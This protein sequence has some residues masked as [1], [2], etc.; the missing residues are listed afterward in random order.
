MDFT[1]SCRGRRVRSWW[2]PEPKGNR[3]RKGEGV[4]A[5]ASVK[6]RRSDA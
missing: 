4:R 3:A 5:A 1:P 6:G 2:R